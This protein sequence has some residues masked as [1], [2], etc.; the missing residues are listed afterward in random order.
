MEVVGDYA[1]D[2]AALVR[3][4]VPPEL[5]N[6]LLRQFQ[7][8]IDPEERG[9]AAAM[10]GSS[11][12]VRDVPELYGFAW[13][14]LVTFLWGLT[15]TIRAIT[16]L[17]LVPSYDYLRLY[18]EGDLC[19]VHSDRPSCEHS[20]S[21]TLDYSD[22]E[23]WPLEIGETAIPEPLK[24]VT[25]DFEGDGYRRFEMQPGDGVLYNG[26]HRRHGRITP[27]PNG[28]SAH[29]FMHWV[30]RGG[31]FADHAFDQRPEYRRPVNFRFA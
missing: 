1:A 17:D 30:L 5:C 9:L 12:L 21:L 7:R 25:D 22:G 19:R 6:A 15:P 29:L 23:V 26:V 14:P 28:W 8:E 13:S 10:T 20:L 2:G 4:L 18:R 31:A 16:G 24:H 27:N 11:L 3:G